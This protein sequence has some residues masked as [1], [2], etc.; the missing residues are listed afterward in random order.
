MGRED[1]VGVLGAFEGMEMISCATH[2]GE[3]GKSWGCDRIFRGDGVSVWGEFS[4]EYADDFEGLFCF[5][6]W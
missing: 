3:A 1:G 2:G 5:P 4:R 6:P